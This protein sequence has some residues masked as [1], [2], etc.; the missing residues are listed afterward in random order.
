MSTIES[1]SCRRRLFNFSHSIIYP[2]LSR[3][4]S[5]F[6][7]NLFSVFHIYVHR[8]L[9][10]SNHCL[11]Y[12]YLYYLCYTRSRCPIGLYICYEIM[13]QKNLPS[14]I[15]NMYRDVISRGAMCRRTLLSVS[16]CARLIKINT[17]VTS[18]KNFSIFGYFQ[19]ARSSIVKSTPLHHSQ[20]DSCQQLEA[21]NTDLPL[22]YVSILLNTK[23]L[24]IISE[25][26]FCWLPPSGP[27]RPPV[28]R[29]LNFP[30]DLH[31]VYSIAPIDLVGKRLAASSSLSLVF[32]NVKP[33]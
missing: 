8:Y 11:I 2:Y 16:S 10:Q 31:R 1:V 3:C 21:P 25:S 5:V 12:H 26:H 28:N 32:P 24:S 4:C 29:L 15:Y 20:S 18:S 6:L 7:S 14:P 17:D 30:L 22:Y 23:V 33:P 27:A 19:P 9:T 13:L